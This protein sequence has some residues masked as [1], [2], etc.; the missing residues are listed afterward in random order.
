MTQKVFAHLNRVVDEA[1]MAHVGSVMVTTKDLETLLDRVRSLEG[2]LR[3][4]RPNTSEVGQL[5]W[6]INKALGDKRHD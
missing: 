6:M 1:V 5:R 4:M 2:A 3:R